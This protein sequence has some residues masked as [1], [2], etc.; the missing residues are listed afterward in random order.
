[1]SEQTPIPRILVTGAAGQVGAELV[2]R[3]DG[4]AVIGLERRAL[5]IGD[6]DAVAHALAEHRPR[7]VINAAAYTAVD[8]AE[9]E[10]EA[11]FAINRDGPA[12][13]AAACA[14][15]GIPLL[16]LSTD[17]VFDGSKAGP[18]TE[19]DPVA[20]LGV[21]GASKEAGE[22]AIRERLRE[23][24]ILR[25]SWVFGARG[26]NFV[27]TMLHLGAE[28]EELRVVAD[29]HGCPT[30]AGAIADSL[31]RLTDRVL[32]GAALPWGTYHYTGTPATTWHGFAEAIFAEA[33]ELGLLVRAPKVLPIE[34]KDY[35]TPARRP[36]NSV[37][38]LERLAALG[39]APRPWRDGLREVLSE[40]ADERL[41]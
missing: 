35:P 38:A 25:V 29:Q 41:S 16:H 5:D 26:H 19:A 1:M 39:L 12:H 14:Q 11:A 28:R 37:L 7:V 40:W 36:A 24:L 8:K 18:Y 2:R 23:H 31:L 17:Y 27:R 4:R 34:T 33:V 13:L 9:T 10:A 20:P 3:A 32:V 22:T 15:A 6:T 21:Y 30:H